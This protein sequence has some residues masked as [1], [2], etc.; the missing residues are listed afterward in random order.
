VGQDSSRSP[1]R[2]WIHV[3]QS[4]SFTALAIMAFHR[5]AVRVGAS[6]VTGQDTLATADKMPA[7]QFETND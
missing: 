3:A 7:L 6:R 2:F 4:I 1:E 5:L